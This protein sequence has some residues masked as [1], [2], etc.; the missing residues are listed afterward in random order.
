VVPYQGEYI[1]SCRVGN[2]SLTDKI[3]IL[4]FDANY[5][6]LSFE[7]STDGEDPRTFLYK[8]KPYAY[9]VDP[10]HSPQ[11][12][13]FNYKVVD[14]LTGK[15]TILSI[16][17]VPETK[18]EIL[19][20][21]WIPIVKDDV[22]YFVVTIDPQICILRCDLETAHCTW[23][24]PF[25]LVKDELKITTSRG[26][27]PLI[28]SEEYDCFIGIGHRT[29]TCHHHRPY[30]YT[31]SKN[32]KEAYIG[33]DISVDRAGVLDALSIYEKDG[34]IFSCIAYYPIQ[35]GDTTQ[36]ISSLYEVKINE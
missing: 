16:D 20:K 11:G 18:V 3:G 31:L 8:G 28:F 5:N 4:K 7:M 34:H 36:A 6:Y 10:Y 35:L 19:G 25:E 12:T 30:L 2:M 22:L 27:T 14:L 32:F 33:P 17:K 13:M 9:V 23:E 15:V 24:T 1:G 21:N 26:S 29:H